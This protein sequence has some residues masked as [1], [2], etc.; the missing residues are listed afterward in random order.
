MTE[1]GPETVIFYP[2]HS[3][4]SSENDIWISGGTYEE[5]DNEV[6]DTHSDLNDYFLHYDGQQW[7]TVW[8]PGYPEVCEEDSKCPANLIK[9][10]WGRS[11]DDVWSLVYDRNS[12]T[13]KLY[14]YEGDHFSLI[15]EV[16]EEL[17]F[18]LALDSSHAYF[19]SIKNINPG[20]DEFYESKLY[21]FSGN[22]LVPMIPPED[23]DSIEQFR[24]MAGTSP[25]DLYLIGG[26]SHRYTNKV[27]HYDGE[28]WSRFDTPESETGPHESKQIFTLAP[29][30]IYSVEEDGVHK[31]TCESE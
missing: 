24:K 8:V 23:E 31:A 7:N 10:V 11:A 16:E 9:A 26:G 13:S 28:A 29:D 17:F 15:L 3:W 5:L 2:G 27:W 4:A 6:G 18:L 14:H 19:T 21:H 22:E 1:Y 25:S 30:H 20:D 12:E